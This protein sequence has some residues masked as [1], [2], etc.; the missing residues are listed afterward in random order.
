M[1][2]STPAGSAT[3]SRPKTR[4]LPPLGRSR[5]S[6]WRISVVLPA[7]LAPTRPKTQ[8][9]GTVRL[10]PSSARLG[11]KRRVKPRSSTTGSWATPFATPLLATIGSFLLGVGVH[12]PVALAEQLDHFVGAEIHLAGLAEQGVHALGE[13]AQ[14][15]AAGQRR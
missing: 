15:L 2:P 7:P 12:R 14:A 6:R 10:T 13:D 5:P 4:T 3:G 1:G 11:P 9:R 8:P